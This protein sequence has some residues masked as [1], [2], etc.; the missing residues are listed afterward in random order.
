MAVDR[1]NVDCAVVPIKLAPAY[2][3]L[4]QFD[5]AWRRIGEAMTAMEATKESWCEAE[6]NRVAGE[7]A[8]SRPHLMRRRRKHISSARSPSHVSSKQ[9]PGS[10]APR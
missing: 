5:D 10:C 2:A 4:G 3:E 9:S 1:S 6:V 7:V 8:L